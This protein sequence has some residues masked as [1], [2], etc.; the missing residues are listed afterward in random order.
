MGVLME[1]LAELEKKRKDTVVYERNLQGLE[2][3]IN[4]DLVW[5]R[6][7]IDNKETFFIF[8][9]PTRPQVKKPRVSR[10]E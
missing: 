6:Q 5:G 4:G 7:K 10:D 8:F 3:E 2:A 9:K 1:N